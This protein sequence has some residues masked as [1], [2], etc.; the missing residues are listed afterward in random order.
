MVCNFWKR[1]EEALGKCQFNNA[2]L[3]IAGRRWS[4][5]N[6]G[7][8]LVKRLNSFRRWTLWGIKHAHKIQDFGLDLHLQKYMWES[9]NQHQQENHMPT[10]SN[11][12][13]PDNQCLQGLAKCSRDI[14]SGNSQSETTYKR[15]KHLAPLICK[16][17]M[18]SHCSEESW[19]TDR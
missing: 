17:C 4:L 15:K 14:T 2:L 1:K 11:S 13:K 16:R 10:D 8:S 7:A 3:W 18:C 5:L 9:C 19:E 12:S 6:K